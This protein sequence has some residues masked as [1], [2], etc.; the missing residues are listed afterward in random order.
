MEIKQLEYFVTASECE[1]FNK[2]AE[3]LYTSQPNVSKVISGLEKELGKKLFE[4][5]SKGIQLTPFGETVRDYARDILR[6]VLMI[7]NIAPATPG[8]KLSVSTWPSI[9]ISRFLVDFYNQMEKKYVIE[10]LEGTA[11]EITDHVKTGAAQLGLVFIAKKQ[12]TAFHHILGHKKLDFEPLDNRKLCVYA[13]KN[14]PLY[15]R[16][17]IDFSQLSQLEFIRGARDYF[18]M[19]HHLESVSMGAISTDQLKYQIYTSSDYLYREALLNTSL[20]GIG[21]DFLTEKYRQ[22]E[23]RAIPVNHC[24]PFLTVGYVTAQN[25]KL[26][27]PAQAFLDKF[28]LML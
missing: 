26:S 28:R 11:E 12:L 15:E 19:E 16:E 1:S 27:R 17:S 7:S 18:S 4:R 8:E 3:C 6:N 13:G 24:E 21:I 5:T 10:H 2:A 20:C 14:H 25:Q 22:Y 9:V 23:I